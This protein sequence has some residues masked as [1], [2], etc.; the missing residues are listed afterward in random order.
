[1]NTLN[2]VDELITRMKTEG[3]SKQEIVWN[4]ALACVDWPYV[5]SSWGDPCTP[6]ERRKRYRM[7]PSHET[8]KTKC[9]AFDSGDCSGC[10]WYPGGERVRCYD[11]RGFTDW[12]LKQIGFD[13]YG[14]TCGTQWKHEANWTAKGTIESMPKG[15]LCCLFVYKDGKWQ[16]TGFGLNDETCEC[17][18]NVQYFAKRKAKWTHWAVPAGLDGAIPDP[19]P[20]PTPTP[21]KRPT[22][23][24]GDRGVYVVELQTDLVKLGYGIGP[25]GIDGVYGKSTKAAVETFQYDHKLVIDGI[26]GPKTWEA[27][28]Q[29]LE[30]QDHQPEPVV[31]YAVVIKDLSLEEAKQICEQYPT[32]EIVEG[33]V[34]R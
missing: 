29:A 22:L 12:C 7:C 20:E 15:V 19:Q 2:Q 11:C 23:R 18:N 13:L 25:C 14:D 21:G 27:I 31:S 26:C 28:D 4:T 16:H 30:D 17:G 1:M 3:L 10:K 34:S 5:Y 6:S 9:K 32:A 8:I 24:Q 33:S